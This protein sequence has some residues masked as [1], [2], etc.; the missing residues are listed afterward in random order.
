MKIVND[1]KEYQVI[2]TGDGYKLENWNGFILE[3]PDPE[4]IWPKS[5]TWIK[6]DAKY[7]RSNT[8]GGH[9]EI[10]NLKYM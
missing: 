3:R 7:I 9:W 2:A 6:S 4:I 1:F 10:Y 5:G 8:G